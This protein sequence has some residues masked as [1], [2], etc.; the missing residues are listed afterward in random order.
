MDQLLDFILPFNDECIM[1]GGCNFCKLTNLAIREDESSRSIYNRPSL[2]QDSEPWMS[3]CSFN[4]L[5]SS[6]TLEDRSPLELSISVE[7]IDIFLTMHPYSRGSHVGCRVLARIG[8]PICSSLT[9]KFHYGNKQPSKQQLTVAL[10]RCFAS[11]M[12]WSF[13]RCWIFEGCAMTSS[14]KDF[15]QTKLYFQWQL[16]PSPRSYYPL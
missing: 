13:G 10:D 7:G 8:Y 11:L 3:T 4:K 15:S 6:N 5:K 12:V 16:F 14:Q 9:N 1:N 2:N